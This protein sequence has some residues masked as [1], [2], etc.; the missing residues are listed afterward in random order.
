MRG[1]QQTPNKLPLKALSLPTSRTTPISPAP[2][3]CMHRRHPT[4][5]TYP[6][7]AQVRPCLPLRPATRCAVPPHPSCACACFHLFYGL[8]NFTPVVTASKILP[9]R[10]NCPLP[11]HLKINRYLIKLIYRRT[12]IMSIKNHFGIGTHAHGLCLPSLSLF[13]AFPQWEQLRP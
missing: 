1:R 11:K 10:R 5:I 2:R 9:P 12:E 6:I 3:P 13:P 4:T 7:F 8:P